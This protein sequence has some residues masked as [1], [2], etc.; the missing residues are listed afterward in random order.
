M[1]RKLA[2]IKIVSDI[3]PIEGKNKIA[4]AMVDHNHETK[5]IRGIICKNCNSALGMFKDNI[6]VMKNAI[7][8]LEK[9]GIYNDE[10]IS[11][12]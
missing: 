6:I 10:K 3:I 5:I 7:Q 4:L 11:A 9:D 8:Y 2:S 12:Y 1:A